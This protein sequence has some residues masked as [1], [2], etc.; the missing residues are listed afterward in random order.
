MRPLTLTRL[1]QG[2]QVACWQPSVLAA[3]LVF[4]LA[5]N[6]ASAA[7]PWIVQPSDAIA[8]ARPDYD[9]LFNGSADPS[10]MYYGFTVTDVDLA[11][12]LT[13]GEEL[14]ALNAEGRRLE[15]V[16]DDDRTRYRPDPQSVLPLTIYLV[17]STAPM[18]ELEAISA[19]FEPARP[20]AIGLRTRGASDSSGPLPHRSLP[21]IEIQYASSETAMAE[22]DVAKP[23]HQLCAYQVLIR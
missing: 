14:P 3:A 13:A 18:P 4:G 20:I 12:Q 21:G 23:D 5:D 6:A 10:W 7:C 9:I 15:A 1:S 11:W 22:L 2:R 16:E 17:V 8:D 19:R